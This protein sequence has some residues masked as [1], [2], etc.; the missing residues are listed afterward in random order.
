MPRPDPLASYSRIGATAAGGLALESASR[1]QAQADWLPAPSA[2][3][4]RPAPQWRNRELAQRRPRPSPWLSSRAK[5]YCSTS[6]SLP[7]TTA[8]TRYPH[9]WTSIT[10]YRSKGL[11]LI[12][13][14]TPEFPPYAGEH[15]RGNVARALRASTRS[16]T[17]TPR[18]TI[19]RTW[20]LYGIRF[21]PSFVLIDK[22][23]AIRYEG[24]GEFHLNDRTYEVWDR[25][26]RELLAE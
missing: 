21:W 18:T 25:R 14:H 2:P 23:G 15:D 6:G 20:N 9:W 13:I 26:I 1:A 19:S 8:P 17:P 7:A 4:R 11:V 24:A 22:R 12:G 5:W 3:T 10:E 16:S